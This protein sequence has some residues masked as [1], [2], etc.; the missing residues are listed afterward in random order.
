MSLSD[1]CPVV[2]KFDTS[3]L[4]TNLYTSIVNYEA[5]HK[6]MQQSYLNENEDDEFYFTDCQY[7]KGKFKR[8]DLCYR[9]RKRMKEIEMMR[10]DEAGDREN[11]LMP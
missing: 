3:G 6:P 1:V 4:V 5:V 8:Q 11:I 2:D 9:R 7:R 10:Q